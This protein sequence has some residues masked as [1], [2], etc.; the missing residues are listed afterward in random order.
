MFTFSKYLLASSLEEA[1]DVLTKN[2][3]NAILGGT[4]YMRMGNRHLATAIDLSSL[5]LSFIR[6]NEDNIE[7]GAMTTFRD[8]EVSDILKRNFSGIVARSVE[9]IV[10]V[11]LR[12]VVTAGATVFSKYGFSDFIPALLALDASVVLF[13]GGEISLEKFLESDIKKDVLVKILIKKSP[14]KGNFQT[15]RKTKSDYAILNVVAANID[16]NIRIAVGAR[17]GRAV[18][19][20]NA[21]EIL[22]TEGLSNENIQAVCETASE[23]LTFGDNM[24]ATGKYRKAVCKVMLKRALT[25]VM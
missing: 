2:R 22:K 7:I 13:N 5:D 8:I 15:I 24:R 6:E 12:N 21:M 17:P 18:L 23:E 1:Y 25:E 16:G 14:G 20:T 3:N 4:A 11:Q 9:D 19:A 10:G